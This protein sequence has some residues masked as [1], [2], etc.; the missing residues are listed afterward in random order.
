MTDQQL[1]S[2]PLELGFRPA[3]DPAHSAGDRF[4]GEV[5]TDD[6]VMVLA[7]GAVMDRDAGGRTRAGAAVAGLLSTLTDHG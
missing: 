5:M 6:A 1:L 4:Y 2:E 7:N 3:G